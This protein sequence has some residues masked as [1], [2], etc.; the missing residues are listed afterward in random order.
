MCRSA[1][2]S[3]MD[4]RAK[5]VLDSLQ[6]LCSK[7]EYCRK[8]IMAKALKA[9]DGDAGAAA[10]VVESLVG[11][12]FVDDLRYAGAFAREKSRLDGWGPVKIRFALRTKGIEAG[13]I[14]RAM[15]SVDTQ[16]AALKLSKLLEAKAASLE[17]DPQKK[18]KLIKFALSRGYEYDQ[19]RDYI[20][21]Y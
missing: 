15:E 3:D 12:R 2:T 5:K 18:F 1:L 13:F 21:L 6:N 11:D 14:E 4:Q 7:R 9:L 17:G 16:A 8:D 10:E 19:I 20:S